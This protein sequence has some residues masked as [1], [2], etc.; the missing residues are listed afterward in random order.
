MGK[1][2]SLKKVIPYL[3]II[4]L[5]TGAYALYQF[6]GPSNLETKHREPYSLIPSTAILVYENVPI[7]GRSDSLLVD[8]GSNFHQLLKLNRLSQKLRALDSLSENYSI[9]GWLAKKKIY[10]AMFPSGRFESNYLLYI[11]LSGPREVSKLGKALSELGYTINERKHKEQVI[12]ELKPGGKGPTLN[13]TMLDNWLILGESPVQIEDAIRVYTEKSGNLAVF[14]ARTKKTS[15][16]EEESI[17][18]NYAALPKFLKTFASDEGGE[19]FAFLGK[20]AD[21]TMLD[22]AIKEDEVLLNGFTE[23]IPEKS[24]FINIFDEQRASS[25]DVK[26]L[27]SNQTS[28]LYFFGF[29]DGP[30]LMNSLYHYWVR[31]DTAQANRWEVASSEYNLEGLYMGLNGLAGLTF[32]ESA[33]PLKAEKVVYLKVSDGDTYMEKLLA[34]NKSEHRDKISFNGVPIELIEVEDLPGVMFGGLM[35]GMAVSYAAHIDN[36]IL[37]S[38]NPDNLKRIISDMDNENVFGKTYRFNHFLE[39]TISQFNI[40]FMLNTHSAWNHLS[41]HAS[42]EVKKVMEES[43][44]YRQNDLLAVQFNRHADRYYTSMILH[45]NKNA[46]KVVTATNSEMMAN[47]ERNIQYGPFRFA[48]GLVYQDSVGYL[49]YKPHGKAA[50]KIDSLSHLLYLAGDKLHA[51]DAQFKNVEGFPVKIGDKIM[52]RN[53]SLLD[54]DNNRNYRI[55]VA[56]ITGNVYLLDMKGT[57]LEPWVPKNFEYRLSGGVRHARIKGKDYILCLAENG[58][59]NVTNRRGEFYPGFP[60]DLNGLTKSPLFVQEG[61]DFTNSYISMLTE[62]GEYVKADFTGKVREKEQLVRLSP[63]SVFKLIPAQNNKSYIISRQTRNRVDIYDQHK[64]PLFEYTGFSGGELLV[65]YFY[66]G[67]GKEW[68]VVTDKGN[69]QLYIFT[70]SGKLLNK[71]LQYSSLPIS[72]EYNERTKEVNF[73]KAY[74][75]NLEKVN[76]QLGN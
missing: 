30:R 73:Y 26:N 61:S 9:S 15:I 40:F 14:K 75:N 65:Q 10:A 47:A 49:F 12:Y 5:G 1:F 64:K 3:I 2:P 31:N 60:I 68:I 58:K 20:L 8:V 74:N 28:A 76:I 62:K 55:S 69:Q 56:D 24:R 7:A 50:Q 57:L 59:L 37:L 71:E 53:L 51:K 22:M 41:Q 16:S 36:Y 25:F 45:F 63:E 46:E 43:S 52:L 6:Y 33:D 17:L 23:L 11:P 4:A 34:L 48:S 44:F 13:Y 72:G 35:K 39:E 54:Y 21:V 42:P 38:D 19:M 27:I 67:A 32:L 70:R 18:V 66:A 29:S